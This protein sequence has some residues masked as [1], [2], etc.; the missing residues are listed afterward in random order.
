MAPLPHKG[1]RAAH[2]A[3]ARARCGAVREDAGL[4]LALGAPFCPWGLSLRSLLL[5]LGAVCGGCPRDRPRCPLGVVPGVIPVVPGMS[6][7]RGDR[8]LVPRVPARERRQAEA[9][10]AL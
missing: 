10:P 9:L 4:R 1:L 2:A 8:E 3:A 7:G 5:S 6:P